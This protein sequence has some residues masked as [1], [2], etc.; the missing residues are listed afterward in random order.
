MQLKSILNR[1]QKQPGFVYGKVHWSGRHC[2]RAELHVHLR[3]RRGSRP[4]CSG[5]GHK[6]RCYDRLHE[7]L[8]QFVRLWAVA[9][10]FVHAPRRADCPRC[11][12]TV[13]LV[14]WAVGAS[15]VSSAIGWR[16]TSTTIWQHG[17]SRAARW[18]WR[19]SWRERWMCPG[20]SRRE[21]SA[22]AS[23]SCA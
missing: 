5:C 3:A 17:V 1:L 20:A 8:F 22:A 10:F 7:R 15:R 19:R 18:T 11:G 16:L 12:V 14:P 6:C 2:G 23:T 9:V 4:V 21:R 13:E